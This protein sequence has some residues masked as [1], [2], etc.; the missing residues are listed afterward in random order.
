MSFLS[1]KI[2]TIII[3]WYIMSYKVSFGVFILGSLTAITSIGYLILTFKPRRRL[4]QAPS[5]HNRFKFTLPEQWQIELKSFE[6]DKQ[7]LH[8]PTTDSLIIS[9]VLDELI[10]LIIKEF[11]QSWYKEI[12][13]SS[14]VTDS[15]AIEIKQV[16]RNIID[17]LEKIDFTKLLVSRILPIIQDHFQASSQAENYVKAKGNFSKFD[18]RDFQLAVAQQYKRGKLHRA[19]TVASAQP[20]DINQKKYLRGKI[21]ACLPFILSDNER[22]NEVGVSLVTEIIACTV[23]SNIVNLVTEADFYNVIIVKLIGDNLRR[24]DQVKQLR[25][26]LEEHTQLKRPLKEVPNFDVDIDS[27]STSI[28]TTTDITSKKQQLTLSNLKGSITLRDILSNPSKLIIFREFLTKKVKESFVDFWSSVEAIKSPLEEETTLLLEYTDI[29]DIHDIY[30]R[31][32]EPGIIRANNKEI[33]VDLFNSKEEDKLNLYHEARTYLLQLQQEVYSIIDNEYLPLFKESEFFENLITGNNESSQPVPVNPEIVHAVESA[34]SQIMSK[35]E[36]QDEQMMSKKELFESSSSLFDEEDD[37]D[38]QSN[39]KLFDSDEES[40]SDSLNFD[41]DTPAPSLTDSELQLAAPGNL[42]LAEEIRKLNDESDNLHRQMAVLEPLI[43]K[44]E[45]TNNLS[46]LK[47]L[48][49]SKQALIREINFKELQKQQYIVQENDNSL[50]GKSRVCIQSYISSNENNKEFT[51]YIIEVQ[52]YSNDDPNITTA[53][54]VVARRFSQFYRL[55]EY[56][57]LKYPSVAHI[58]F[59]K[60]SMLKFQHQ[61]LIEI[62][63]KALERYLQELIKIPEICS[64]KAF[65]SF[66]SSEN[67]SLHKNQPFGDAEFLAN[68]WYRGIYDKFMPISGSHDIP[69][70]PIEAESQIVENIRDMEKELKQFDEGTNTKTTVFVKPICDLLITVFRLSNSKSWLRGRALVVI[71]QQLFGT[72]IEKKVYQ[73]EAQFKTEQNLLELV[74]LLKNTIFPNGKFK[75]PPVLRT[76]YQQSNTRQEAKGLWSVFMYETCS[77]IFG[78]SNTTFASNALFRMIQNDYLNKHLVFEIF[79]ELFNEIF[80]EVANS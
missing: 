71:L 46:E 47:V 31:Y 76:L 29:N 37:D 43:I 62:R 58:K 15:I 65:R 54:W 39:R 14:L 49:R 60:R 1:V 17:R 42:N 26:A 69:N 67:F 51:L 72:T 8:K 4:T 45:L 6:T 40:D 57:K 33:F 32:I 78:T 13:Q 27:L 11:I 75:D 73:T 12:T 63:Q 23:L 41:S 16:I 18:S 48:Q 64:N 53:G 59:P 5:K 19:V 2:G 35:Q 52:K 24:R 56:L 70:N 9:T 34:F 55:H 36:I 61:Q 25:A 21:G 68:K 30:S 7:E 44:A 77:T 20:L 50:Y 80:P 3:L 22:D 10:Q 74:L 66:L 38:N 28:E 79:D